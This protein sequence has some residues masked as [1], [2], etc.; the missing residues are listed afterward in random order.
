MHDIVWRP[1]Q[2]VVASRFWTSF[3][4]LHNSAAIPERVAAL[5]QV[6]DDTCGVGVCV[7][8]FNK[9]AF[10]HNNLD[11][12]EF[13]VTNAILLVV[14]F[15]LLSMYFLLSISAGLVMSVVLCAT[16]MLAMG[17]LVLMDEPLSTGTALLNLLL[18]MGVTGVNELPEGCWLP[19]IVLGF[20][21]C[22]CFAGAV[23][24]QFCCSQLT[25]ES[26]S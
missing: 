18:G 23:P 22:H 3:A 5:R 12:T 25:S 24:Y 8:Y 4:F 2:G 11:F 21:N 19:W 16:L 7:P 14:A 17:W 26:T 10:W 1:G 13:L 6:C 15:S 20:D 9:M